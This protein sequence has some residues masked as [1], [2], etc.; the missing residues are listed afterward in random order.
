MRVIDASKELNKSV[1]I[2]FDRLCLYANV[3]DYSDEYENK[4]AL[5]FLGGEKKTGLRVK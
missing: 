3:E 2:F 5:H 1:F 4:L